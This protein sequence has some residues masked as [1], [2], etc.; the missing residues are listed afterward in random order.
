MAIQKKTSLQ[1]LY[2]NLFSLFDKFNFRALHE[3]QIG[4][5]KR[6]NL[7]KMTSVSEKLEL[8]TMINL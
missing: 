7:I 5:P 4:N 6:V 8:P 2:L 1:G 3:I